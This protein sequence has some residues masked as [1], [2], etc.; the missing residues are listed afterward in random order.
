M[1]LVAI[2]L[3]MTRIPMRMSTLKIKRNKP[4]CPA[5]ALIKVP[6]DNDV[7]SPSI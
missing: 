6:L 2:K 4:T 1:I 7:D 3:E 5:S